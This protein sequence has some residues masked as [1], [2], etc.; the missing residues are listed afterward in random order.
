MR[1]TIR[2]PHLVLVLVLLSLTLSSA[3][4]ST[5]NNP[6]PLTGWTHSP[7]F[8]P[9]DSPTSHG[10]LLAGKPVRR[11]SPVIADIDG[12]AQNGPEAAVGGSDGQLYIYGSGGQ[13]IW[14]KQVTS[15]DDSLHAAPAVGRILGA[16]NAPYVI[17]AYG[18]AGSATCDGG[19]VAYRGNDGAEAWRFSTKSWAASQGYS[20]GQYGVYSSPAVA[21]T[22][23]DGQM[24][25]GFGSFDRHV[26]LLN[27]NGSVRWYYHAADSVWSSPAFVN[28]DADA[29]LE[30]VIGTD[31][32]GNPNLIPPTQSGGYVYAFDTEQRSPTRVAFEPDPSKQPAPIK[33]RSFFD[34]V[35]FSSPVI[36]DVLATNNGSEIVVGSGCYHPEGSTNK[37][38]R[39]IKI[40]RPSDGVTLQ[41]LNAPA[42]VQSSVA[43]GDLDDDGALEIVATVSGA[44]DIGGDGLGRVMA[45]KAS[46]PNPIW[47]TVPYNPNSPANDASGNDEHGGDLQSPVI[48]DLDGNGSLEVIVANFW[49]VHILNGRDGQA[50]TCQN[51]SCGS[52]TALYAWG[53]VKST[54]AVGDLNG[55]GKPEVLIGGMHVFN[56]DKGMF[57]AW[58]GFEGRLGSPTGRQRAYSAPWPMFRGDAQ[59]TGVLTEQ[60]IFPSSSSVSAMIT[61]NLKRTNQLTFKG[62][63]GSSINWRASLSD[64]NNLVQLNRTEGTS[65]DVLELVINP[66]AN[67][68]QT[69]TGSYTASLTVQSDG[70]ADTNIAITITVVENVYDVAIPLVAR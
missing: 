64:P 6:P 3:E 53:T 47:T 27:A 62:P 32:F 19:V 8:S 25:I 70:L 44:T 61:P 67:L 33:W 60:K 17:M 40:L 5:K 23:G 68:A 14:R 66:T 31:I 30:M 46:S 39:W 21:D 34:Q 57:Y 63:N 9:D 51:T 18:V 1:R 59:H 4:A 55:D 54:P 35:I 48:A 22:N 50:L 2:L 69:A 12:N 26:Y 65:A 38:G 43:V 20:E 16:N 52:K 7:T 36:A 58:T 56:G 28:L 11:S 15:C 37:R 29:N 45:W 13:L 24:E 49:S 42:C 10:I 41:T